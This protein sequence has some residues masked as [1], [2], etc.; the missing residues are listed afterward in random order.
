MTIT[1]ILNAVARD[2]RTI[3]CAVWAPGCDR[4]ATKT[5][6]IHHP[7]PFDVTREIIAC[8]WLVPTCDACEVYI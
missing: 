2:P 5:L 7:R 1:Q 8:F 6:S 4:I 3:T